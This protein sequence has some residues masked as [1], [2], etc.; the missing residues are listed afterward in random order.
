MSLDTYLLFTIT[1]AIIIFS[2]GPTAILVASQGA[3]NGITRTV[4][5]IFGITLATI[6]YF[7]LSATG[8]ASLILASHL[9][10]SIIKWA[11]VAYL[12][13]LGLTAI[14][15]KSGGINVNRSSLQKNRTTLFVHGFLVEFSNPKA[16]LYFAAIIPQFLDVTK[17][18]MTQF[19]AMGITTFFLQIAIYSAYTY[20]GDQLVR[21]GVKDWIIKAINKTA[22]GALIF[23]GLKMAAVTANN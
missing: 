15:S 21:G 4:F 2:P 23:A 7:T 17:P 12:L 10:F 22:G 6:T 13:Y 14:F 19:L 3:A 9:M 11:G 18:I 16:L 1:T 5:S 8:I 20:M